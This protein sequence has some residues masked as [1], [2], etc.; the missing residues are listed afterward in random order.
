MSSTLTCTEAFLDQCYR[1]RYHG[2]WV[3][4]FEQRLIHA[5]DTDLSR[6]NRPSA[7]AQFRSLCETMDKSMRR[8]MSLFSSVPPF[9][10]EVEDVLAC[11][12]TL[13]ACSSLS[14]AHTNALNNSLSHVVR[15]IHSLE[16]NRFLKAHFLETYRTLE[17]LHSSMTHTKK[18][19]LLRNRGSAVNPSPLQEALA[20]DAAKFETFMDAERKERV[21]QNIAALTGATG[22][23]PS[24]INVRFLMGI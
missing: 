14:P 8:D 2:D 7:V 19:F 24:A 13:N 4:E 23:S 17:D 6:M 18:E 20:Q 21:A 15:L 5:I 1:E 22:G 11:I 16:K 10:K 12:E 3:D 9:I